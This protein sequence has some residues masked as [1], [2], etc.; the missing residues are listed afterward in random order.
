VA[1]TWAGVER[2]ITALRSNASAASCAPNAS[3]NDDHKAAAATTQHWRLTR[4]A[5]YFGP[6]MAEYVIGHI[7]SRERGFGEYATS[8][9]QH[10]W[11]P[12]KGCVLSLMQS[13]RTTLCCPC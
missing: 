3:A 8:Q 13:L 7:I 2:T 1:L 5:G 12:R 11:S 6:A 4:F 9:A 10:K